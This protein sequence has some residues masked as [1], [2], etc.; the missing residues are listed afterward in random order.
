MSNNLM[1]EPRT[2]AGG[3]VIQD[4]VAVGTRLPYVQGCTAINGTAGITQI[5]LLAAV[6]P[7]D[8]EVLAFLINAPDGA[9]IKGSLNG[10]VIN[11]FCYNGANPHVLADSSFTFSVRERGKLGNR[12]D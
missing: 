12:T 3:Y 4:S 1:P 5:T 11:I 9:T 6:D 7:R 10:S 8:I 2:V